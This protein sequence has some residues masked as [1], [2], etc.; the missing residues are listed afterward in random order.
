MNKRTRLAIAGLLIGSVALT[1]ADAFIFRRMRS[2]RS[3]SSRRGL[4]SRQSRGMSSMFT[5]NQTRSSS[6]SYSPR[7]NVNGQWSY[8]DDYIRD[9]LRSTHGIDVSGFGRDQMEK[10]HDN[11][12]NGREPMQ[13]VTQLAEA[14]IASSSSS[15]PSCPDGTCPVAAPAP[16]Q[17]APVRASVKS[18]SSCPSGTCPTS[19]GS[20]RSTQRR[21]LFRWR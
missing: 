1:S 14:V 19:S 6:G 13:G 8:S 15:C 20:G 3:S 16:V 10:I 5:R 7:W 2:R 18:N 9:H 21:G 17:A 11:M 4:I 12:H